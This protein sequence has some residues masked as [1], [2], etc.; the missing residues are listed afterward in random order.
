MAE[1]S[2]ARINIG[3][4]SIVNNFKK[5]MFPQ[6][7]N[8]FN[9]ERIPKANELALILYCLRFALSLHT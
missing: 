8:Q 9:P 3:I 7:Y 5:H 6:Q 1:Y 4:I 2:A